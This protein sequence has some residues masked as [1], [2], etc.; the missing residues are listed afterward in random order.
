MTTA[1]QPSTPTSPAWRLW[2]AFALLAFVVRLS[3]WWKVSS[4]PYGR[5]LLWDDGL[6]HDGALRIL[7]GTAPSGPYDQSPLPAYAQAAV[8][9]LF[10]PNPEAWCLAGVML[11]T[12]TCVAVGLA[13]RRAAGE[14]AGLIA[15]LLA[16]LCGPLVLYSAVPLKTALVTFLFAVV[17][18]ALAVAVTTAR[19]GVV[20][21]CALVV[22]GGVGAVMSAQGQGVAL[23]PCAAI[24]VGWA[25][26]VGA[27]TVGRRLRRVAVVGAG[28]VVGVALSAGPFV[29]HNLASSDGRVWLS[30]QGGINLY[31]GSGDVDDAPYYRPAAFASSSPREQAVQFF[32]EARRRTGRPLSTADAASYWTGETWRLALQ[33]PRRTLKHLFWKIAAVVHVADRCDHF[34]PALVGSVAPVVGWPFVRY[35]DVVVLALVAVALVRAGRVGT[36][37]PGRRGALVVVVVVT[38][39]AVAAWLAAVVLFH[40]NARYRTPALAGLLPLGAVALDLGWAAVVAGRGRPLRHAALAAVAGLVLTRLPVPGSD[41]RTALLNTHGAVLAAAGD[42]AGAV[43]AWRTSVDERGDFSVYAA[44][45][46]AAHAEPERALALLAPWV[47]V[48]GHGRAAVWA[49]QARL[50]ERLGRHDDAIAAR[51][52]SLDDNPHQLAERMRLTDQLRTRGDDGAARAEALLVERLLAAYRAEAPFSVG[53]WSTLADGAQR[54]SDDDGARTST[55]DPR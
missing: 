23:L 4:S 40:P 44:V 24:A 30:V 46:L 21:A 52:I 26:A 15:L 27:P 29:A 2:V 31:L 33:H 54:Q 43:D 11:G 36:G 19:L 10:G 48:R 6:Q 35:A 50:F 39:V 1:P 14:R 25:A 12:A 7:A 5:S 18:L 42:V 28:Y 16:A 13:A 49:A 20:V 55:P 8:Y 53:P 47:G 38:G 3:A 45:S 41:D 32:E 17:V 37:P 9:A 22:G 34:D 51:R